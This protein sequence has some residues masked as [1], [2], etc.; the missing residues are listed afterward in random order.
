M[1]NPGPI[2]DAL[3]ELL[4]AERSRPDPAPEV[5]ER[6]YARLAA[7][8]GLPPLADVPQAVA[9][10]PA[11]PAAPAAPVAPALT[12][13]VV[14]TSARLGARGI[15]TFVVGAAVGAASYGTVQHLRQPAVP[16]VPAVPAPSE[17]APGPAEPPA[18]LPVASAAEEDSAPAAPPVARP[19]SA[20][21]H[22]GSLRDRGLAAE[23]KLIEMA[24]SAL[25]RGQ[26]DGALA[27]LQRHARAHRHGQLAEERESLFVQALVAK[28]DFARARERAAHFHRHYPHSLFAPVVDQALRSIP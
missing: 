5:A 21:S 15:L 10:Q 18:P 7:G 17:L 8:L 22:P 27:S 20:T 6:V 11:P 25:A 14:K 24:R 4:A 26:T 9:P 12:A 2:P 16:A 19:T 3:R 28:G 23:R 1:M 13:A